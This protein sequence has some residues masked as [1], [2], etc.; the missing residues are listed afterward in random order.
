MVATSMTK[1]QYTELM[2]ITTLLENEAN[3]CEKTGAYLAGCVMIGAALEASMIAVCECYFD[4]IPE[5]LIPKRKKKNL[6][7]IQ[8][9]FSDLIKIARELG[10]LP[11]GLKLGEEWDKKKAKIGDYAEVVRQLRN[12]VHPSRYIQDMP[13]KK[14]SKQYYQYCREVYD[15][16]VEYLLDKIHSSLKKWYNK[17]KASNKLGAPHS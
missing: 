5:S 6:P 3:K 8:W 9:P 10:W 15:V 1:K 13:R 11:A 17:Q 16:S 2:R 14:I 12:L 7:I 4:E